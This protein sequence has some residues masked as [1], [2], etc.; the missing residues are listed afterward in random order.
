MPNIFISYRRE[1]TS[2]DAGHLAADL[3]DRFGRD[4]VF[5]DIDAISGGADF[6]LRIKYAL[7]QSRV[8]FA[9]IGE[10]WLTVTTQDG[11]RRLDDERDYVRREIAAALARED[12][13]VVPVLVEGAKMP[14]AAQLPPDLAPLATRNAV[15]LSNK[16]WRYDV[17]QLCRIAMQYDKWWHRWWHGLPRRYLVA[18][19]IAALAA[20]AA[21]A[22][23]L[24]TGGSTAG[25]GGGSCGDV[26]R[27][28][29]FTSC[30]F[31]QNVE[32]VYNAGPKGNA[33]VSAFSPA[34][35]KYISMRCVVV[36]GPKVKC[37][38]GKRAS[39]TFPQR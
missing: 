3:C 28:V 30:P 8:T 24:A 34:T 35:G 19:P 4:N 37:T 36:E 9:L 25:G 16:R 2:G 29:Q 1:D 38:G 26:S 7:D 31:A 10:R 12:V 21:V 22:I 5:I 18:A 15:D 17:R 11:T 33:V 13:T 39:V 32:R 20:I 6:E 14:T 23:V 27:V